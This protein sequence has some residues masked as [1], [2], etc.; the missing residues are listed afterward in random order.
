MKDYI[1]VDYIKGIA[2]LNQTIKEQVGAILA[3]HKLKIDLKIKPEFYF[4]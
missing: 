1:P 4:L 2:V 3:D